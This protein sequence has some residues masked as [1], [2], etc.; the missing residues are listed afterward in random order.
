MMKQEQDNKSNL[1]IMQKNLKSLRDY[2]EVK[3]KIIMFIK[4]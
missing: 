3:Y 4:G 1:D 2:V